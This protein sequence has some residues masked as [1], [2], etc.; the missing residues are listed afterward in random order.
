MTGST[1]RIDAAVLADRTTALSAFEKSV[2]PVWAGR[3]PEE[4]VASGARLSEAPTPVMTLDSRALNR[5]L[6]SML[7]WCRETGVGFAPHGKTTMSPALWAAQLHAGAWGITVA[8]EAQLRVAI[9]VGVPRIMLANLLVRPAGVAWLGSHLD[10]HPEQSVVVWLDSLDA[11]GIMSRALADAGVSRPVQVLVEL[12]SPGARTGA[13]TLEAAHAVAAAVVAAPQLRLAGIA[14]YEG[15]I[16]HDT[17]SAAVAMIREYLDAMARLHRSLLESYETDAPIVTAGGSAYFDLVAEVL[18]PARIEGDG[19]QVVVRSGAVVTH[20][21]GIYV[22]LTPAA[23]REGPMLQSAM[24]VWSRVISTPEPTI[25]Y[26]DS[27]RRDLPADEGWP[28][29][30]DVRRDGAV[31]TAGGA[32]VF[33]MNDQHTHIRQGEGGALAVGDVIRLGL[34]H[35]CTTF[36]KWRW[37]LVVDDATSADPEI[38]DI[39]RTH[40]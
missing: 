2:P 33:A 31:V 16:T 25:A 7:A 30:L 1:S 36:D 3:T 40:F 10:E 14:G 19:T 12:G 18:D 15:I 38:V 20:D 37:I 4:I 22:D 23:S 32:T 29:L 27:G 8:N 11:V 28:V 9:E 35:P 13:R 17:D 6:E 26:L 24:N 39:I 34:S 5:N 21:D